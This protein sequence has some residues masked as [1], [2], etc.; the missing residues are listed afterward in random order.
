MDRRHGTIIE[1]K[2]RQ[3]ERHKTMRSKD[4]G[5]GRRIL[6]KVEVPLSVEDITTYALRYLV[7]VGDDDPKDTIVN[8]NKREIFN[9][10]KNAI[11]RWGTEEPKVYVAEHMNGS[12]QP[13]HQVVKFKFPECD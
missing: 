4:T 2:N 1:L 5:N 9:M 6:A 8:S 12:V 7:E 10:A 13:I 3:D 11:F